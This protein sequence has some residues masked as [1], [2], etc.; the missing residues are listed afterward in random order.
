MEY[1]CKVG[2]PTGEVVEQTFTAPDE[3]V[4][5][6]ELEHKGYYLFSMRRALGLHRLQL[7]RPRVSPDLLMLF[8]QELSALLKA[9]LPLLQSLDVML[10]RQRHPVF[11]RSLTTVR[12]KVKSGTALSEAFR[13]E[14][15]LY[16]PIL[17]ASI[18]AGER[19]G[20]LELVLRRFAQYMRLNLALKKKAVSA[21]VYPAVLLLLMLGL[22][23]I[24]VVH[25]IP[26]FQDFYADF[27]VELP[28]LTRVIMGFST[29]VRANLTWVV[30]GLA[31]AVA[32]GAYLLRQEGAGIKVDRFLLRLP[33][34]GHLMR[35]Y[36]TSQLAR[37][38]SS[39]LAGG[40]PLIN[41][42]GVAADSI[43]N[44]AMADA[45]ARATPLIREG[46]SLTA[47]LESTGVLD[48]LALEMI[49]VGEQTG[50]LADMLNAIADFF[51]EEMEGR[52]ATVLALVEPILLVVMAVVVAGMLLAFYLPLFEAISAIQS[53]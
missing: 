33:Y 43:G 30:L 41:A 39:L 40:L 42:M 24:L 21:S 5:R 8:G 37:T 35:M 15:T 38:L 19:G 28:L 23:F 9:G 53:R 29:A 6:A 52:L 50:A 25:V 12:E 27:D 34:I 17:A 49:K 7:R 10:E 48:H 1:V 2:T 4:L 44:R 46:K 26:Q 11:K 3:A 22:V 36:A 16:P 13:A 47:A 51:D 31:A 14:G 20:N 45:V 32:G 18:L